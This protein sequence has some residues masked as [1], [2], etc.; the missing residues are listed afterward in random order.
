MYDDNP[1]YQKLEEGVYYDTELD[2]TVFILDDDESKTLSEILNREPDAEDGY[3]LTRE[4]F[5]GIFNSDLN[6]L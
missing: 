2:E 4:E 6:E 1:R 5:D 3:R